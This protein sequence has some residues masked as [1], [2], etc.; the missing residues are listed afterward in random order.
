MFLRS[1]WRSVWS[2]ESRI[3][4]ALTMEDTPMVEADA[5]PAPMG[6]GDG[7]VVAGLGEGDSF[8]VSGRAG[9]VGMVM[10]VAMLMV[11]MAHV[12]L[13]SNG[14]SGHPNRYAAEFRNWQD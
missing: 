8:P 14:I 6:G 11:E 4:N 7:T 5:S 12:V 1:W 3:T 13:L 9:A 2:R 10:L